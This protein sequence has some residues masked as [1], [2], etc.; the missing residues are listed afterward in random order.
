MNRNRFLILVLTG[1][2]SILSLA[3]EACSQSL[4]DSLQ[5][6]KPMGSYY[7]GAYPNLF[8]E[9]LGVSKQKVRAAID[10][11]FAQLFYGDDSAQRVDHPAGSDMAYVEDILHK[12][13]R[14]EGMSVRDDDRRPAKQKDGV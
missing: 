14:S 2:A 11:A 4:R 9:L 7:T 8:A 1:F 13:V 5:R 6:A 3:Q 12:D 10:S